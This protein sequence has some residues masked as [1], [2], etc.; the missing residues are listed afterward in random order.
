[1]ITLYSF[2]P[3]FGLIDASPFCAKAHMLLKIAGLE[4][5]V[6]TGGYKKAPKG[7][8]PYID[9][10][11]K[12][13]ADST[14][15][16]LHIEN[17][18]G[19]DF[20]ASLDKRQ[21][22]MAWAVEKMFEDH[23]YWVIINERWCNDENFDRGPRMYF[24]TAP[25]LIR[26]LVVSMIKK[27][28]AKS[29]FNHGLGRHRVEE[30]HLLAEKAIDAVADIIGD[31]NYLMGDTVCGAD[32]TVFAFLDSL[33]CRHFET[34]VIAIVEKHQNLMAYRK[35]MRNEWLADQTIEERT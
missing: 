1:M 12:I 8:L 20:N 11:G 3:A 6:D 15:I 10:E 9:D 17:K 33:A 22:G 27:K 28:V 5:A 19:F 4:Y 34:P 23:L 24:D 25:A 21:A 35:R 13:I 29:V 7:K 14:F 32:A 26:P 31:N 18:Y 30:T 2:G 16:R